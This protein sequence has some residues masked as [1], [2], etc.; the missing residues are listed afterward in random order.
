MADKAK[1]TFM[2]Y[3]AGD[4]NLSAAGD[5][6]LGEMRQVGS[7]PEVNIIVQFDNQGN[8][9]TNRYR[10][11]F[12]GQPDLV[13]SLGE[14][15]SGDPEVLEEFVAWT[16]Q[17]YPAER[18]ALVLWSHGSAWEPAELDKIAR[19]VNAPNYSTKEAA[20]RSA[21]PMGKVIFRPSLERIFQLP[22]AGERA[23]CVDDGSGH[24]LDTLELEKVLVKAKEVLGQDID[25][26][27]MDACLMSNLEVA[28]QVQ[29]Y[30]K[31]LVAS[32]E[33]EPN[34]GWPYERLLRHLV[35][36]PSLPTAQIAEH[37]VH[38]Y[39][40]SYIDRGYTD[41]VTQT[42]LELGR[43]NELTD[44]LDAL[45]EAL[46]AENREQM[47]FNLWNAMF[48][49]TRFWGDTL[50]DITHFCEQLEKQAINPATRQAS[51]QVRAALAQGA[52]RFVAAER[53]HG[54]K[55]EHCGGVTIYLPALKA[56][57]RFYPELAFASQHH[58]VKVIQS[59]QI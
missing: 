14:T 38:D 2:V 56:M 34:D 1:W 28:F 45:A 9:G 26:L 20:E 29:P 54:K 46:L 13:M 44:P 58:W 5:K 25:L 43:V 18:Y 55:V 41:A 31:Y 3:M 6:D 15:D 53:H 39:I 51:Q 57:S 33:S 4:N 42:A 7:T 59:Y 52:G 32:E 11:L 16:A 36:D 37:I 48:R 35:D 19:S 10:V 24:S 30:A 21:S 8:R 49:T 22:S 50:L 40:Q 23:I 17:Q 27:G 47:R 12:G